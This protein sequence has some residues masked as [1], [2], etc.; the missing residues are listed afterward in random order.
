[1]DDRRMFGQISRARIIRVSPEMFLHWISA[2]NSNK[3]FS[4]DTI[5]VYS[6]DMSNLVDETAMPDDWKLEGVEVDWFRGRTVRLL[7]SSETFCETEHGQPF[8]EMWPVITEHTPMPDRAAI[9]P[10][11]A[12]N[13]TTT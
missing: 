5:H 3:I 4:L 6:G 7:I 10:M 2:L 1:M 8:P 12:G 13:G 9:E 11:E